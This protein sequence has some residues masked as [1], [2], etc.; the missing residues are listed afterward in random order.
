MLA[1][2]VVYADPFDLVVFADNHDMSRVYTQLNEDYDA[3]KM[4]MV[5]LATTRGT[6]QIY[7]GTEILMANRESEDHGL[8]RSDFP[9]G[10]PGDKV[11]AFTGKGLTR[12]Q[13]EAQQ[14]MRELLNW[15]KTQ[16]VIA[17]G[18]SASVVCN[19]WRR[20]SRDSMRLSPF[21]YPAT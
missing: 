12:Q 10:W 16:P 1:N 7:Y 3:W 19:T 5:F 20:V 21:R 14:F 9:G 8:I 18:D 11:N 15:R 17:S 4:A 13:R 6:P 2:D